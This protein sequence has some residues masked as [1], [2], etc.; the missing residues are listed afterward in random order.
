MTPRW[1]C[2][3]IS[4]CWMCCRC[5][6]SASQSLH[7]SRSS[8]TALAPWFYDASS[9]P[10]HNLSA[11]DHRVRTGT[12]LAPI[13]DRA[14]WNQQQLL[15]H[16]EF[17]SLICSSRKYSDYLYSESTRLFLSRC[18]TCCGWPLSRQCQEKKVF[19]SGSGIFVWWV[20]AL[21]VDCV[22][23]LQTWLELSSPMFTIKSYSLE[24]RR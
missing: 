8:G 13:W 9:L 7:P 20:L 11:S 15:Q 19:C 2:Y 4:S 5:N 6:Q 3:R 12:G 16:L 17:R 23:P 14:W 1:V 10:S 22:Y 18:S 24:V 21:F